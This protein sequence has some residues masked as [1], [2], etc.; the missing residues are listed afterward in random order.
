MLGSSLPSNHYLSFIDITPIVEYKIIHVYVACNQIMQYVY[1]IKSCNMCTL[2]RQLKCKHHCD[3]PCSLEIGTC[4]INDAGRQAAHKKQRKYMFFSRISPNDVVNSCVIIIR[5]SVFPV[6]FSSR[7]S[8]IS[9]TT[10]CRFSIGTTC[11]LVES[12][13]TTCFEGI[14]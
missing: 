11:F 3:C 7:I 2:L 1:P 13:Q 5:Q 4:I 12:R 6:F 14:N 9:C 8:Y 10:V